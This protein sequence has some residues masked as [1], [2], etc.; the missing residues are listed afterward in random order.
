LRNPAGVSDS[1]KTI[2]TF[3]DPPTPEELDRL[4]RLERLL[5]R[6]S[7]RRWQAWEAFW[8]PL[9]ELV[10]AWRRPPGR[11]GA[12]SIAVLLAVVGFAVTHHL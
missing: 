3:K 10:G 11:G 4:E 8:A 9:T 7:R 1:R 5:A 2:V 12:G 6:R